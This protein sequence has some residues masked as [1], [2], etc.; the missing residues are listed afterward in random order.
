MGYI[1]EFNWVLKLKPEQGLDEENLEVN[2]IYDYSK[3]GARNYP[4]KYPIL[5][6][7]NNWEAVGSVEVLGFSAGN[8]I[9]KGKYKII[10]IY[11]G[12]DKEVLTKFL[13]DAIIYYKK[14]NKNDFSELKAT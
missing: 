14:D 10:K 3:D 13:Q 4:L 8:D 7:N 5:L 9:T 11:E 2:Q 1:T 12:I 6:V